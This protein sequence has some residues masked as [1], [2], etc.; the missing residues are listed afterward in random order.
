MSLLGRNAPHRVD[1]QLREYTR[2]AQG[3]QVYQQVGELIPV[4]CMVEPVRDWASAEEERTL[5]LQVID[6][7]VVR[8]AHWPGDV[9]S[10]VLY[11]GGWYETVGVPQRYWVGKRTRH[12]RI[13]LKWIKKAG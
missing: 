9:H 11:D 8:S 1:V 4:K 6:M 2:N 7:A 10:H 3:L 5:G 13:T 12:W